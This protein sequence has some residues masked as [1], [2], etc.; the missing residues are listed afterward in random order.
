MLPKL[1]RLIPEQ[2]EK[3]ATL[4]SVVDDWNSLI[5]FGLSG[6]TILKRLNTPLKDR[7]ALNTRGPKEEGIYAKSA[8]AV[9][10]VFTDTGIGSGSYLG[11]NLI[12]TNMHVVGNAKVAG[13]AFKPREEG[14]APGNND[15]VR[16]EIIKIDRVRDL[17]LLKIKNAPSSAKILE[18]GT[19][20]EIKVGAD[21]NA[22]GHPTGQYWTY[23]RGII[24]QIR[25]NFQWST[26]NQRHEADVIQ[27]QTPINPGNSGGPLISDSGKIIGVNTFKRSG[28]EAINYA[29]SVSD[30]YAFLQASDYPQ[31][32][33]TSGKCKPKKLYEGRT[34]SNDAGLISIDT[35]CDGKSDF[36]FVTPDDQKKNVEAL[37]DSNYDG[38]IDIF[39]Y[40]KNRDGR[41]DIS[42]WDTKFVGKLDLV[43]FHPDGKL[44][45]SRFEKFD[46]KR[47]Y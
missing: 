33:N 18:L 39:V 42:F 32:P 3:N 24:S 8:S 25:K 10:I 15:I 30:V 23:T 31:P 13:V 21:V 22:I 16:A 28:A 43:G 9:V 36:F 20:E 37:V 46:P 14:A 6:N 29:V 40:G 17:A 34:K 45:P 2:R 4:P 26:D 38:N 12:L 7:G 47:R 5:G 11:S 27:T 35:N 1:K 19:N 41:W 44:E